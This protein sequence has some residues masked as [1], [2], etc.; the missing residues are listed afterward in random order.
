[1][2]KKKGKFEAGYKATITVNLLMITLAFLFP[3]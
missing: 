3:N 2:L 1:M